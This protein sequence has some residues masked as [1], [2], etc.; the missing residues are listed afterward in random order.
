MV[1]PHGSRAHKKGRGKVVPCR[2]QRFGNDSN[3]K[4]GDFVSKPTE[5]SRNHAFQAA[6][7]ENGSADPE[8]RTLARVPSWQAG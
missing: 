3:P 1:S 4:P 2:V 8:P 5:F 7:R 6:P